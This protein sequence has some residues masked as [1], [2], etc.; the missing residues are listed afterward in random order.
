MTMLFSVSQCAH[1]AAAIGS[2]SGSPSIHA[3]FEA[4]VCGSV[5]MV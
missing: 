2:I 5:V 4:A 1:T 3:A